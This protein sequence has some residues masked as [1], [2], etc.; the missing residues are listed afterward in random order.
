MIECLK[1][2]QRVCQV[3]GVDYSHSL[4][5]CSDITECKSSAVSLI[6]DSD[7][8][9]IQLSLARLCERYFSE[10]SHFCVNLPWSLRNALLTGQHCTEPSGLDPVVKQC[11]RLLADSLSRFVQTNEFAHCLSVK[12][13]QQCSQT[14]ALAK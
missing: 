7:P 4:S 11:R 1:W 12:T 13:N 2:K 5:L 9:T 6:D 10:D 8:S 3:T 14:E